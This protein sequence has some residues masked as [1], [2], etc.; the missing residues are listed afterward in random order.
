MTTD[1]TPRQVLD[2]PMPPNDAGASTTVRDYLVE[3]LAGVWR[4]GEGFSGKRPFG[5]S[6][7]QHELCDALAA[8]GFVEPVEHGWHGPAESCARTHGLISAAIEAMKE[9]R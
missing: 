5:N 3:L 4:E 8:A 9:Q 2:T 6:D 7:W 1:P